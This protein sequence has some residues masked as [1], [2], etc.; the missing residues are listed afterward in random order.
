MKLAVRPQSPAHLSLPLVCSSSTYLL[1]EQMSI[2][3][4]DS[5]RKSSTVREKSITLAEMLF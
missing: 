1:D 3:G 4:I 5:K 2:Q